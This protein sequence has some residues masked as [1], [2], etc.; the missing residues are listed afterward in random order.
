[1]HNQGT[2]RLGAWVGSLVFENLKA[3]MK[4]PMQIEGKGAIA[5]VCFSGRQDTPPPPSIIYPSN[6]HHLCRM[7]PR[8]A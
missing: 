6:T 1:M 2:R 8:M 3:M 5:E 7:L 4:A